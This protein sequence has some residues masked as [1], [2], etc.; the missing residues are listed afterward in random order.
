MFCAIWSG[1]SHLPLA[2]RYGLLRP[3][4]WSPSVAHYYSA[5]ALLLLGTY[6]FTVWR[7]EGRNTYSLT[8]CGLL[9]VVLLIALAVTGLAMIL[10]NLP[11]FSLFGVTYTVVKLLHLVCAL[12]LLP[13]LIYRLCR[14]WAGGDG[15]L[16]P[17][18][19]DKGGCRA[20][21]RGKTRP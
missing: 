10:H 5:A 4:H 7:L 17:R 1:L 19:V 18:N 14:G 11:S 20:P 2:A 9:R 21:G 12:A 6:G 15:W 3:S 16:C 8:R 13:L